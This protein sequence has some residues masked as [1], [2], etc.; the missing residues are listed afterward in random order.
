MIV[1]EVTDYIKAGNA[2]L[3]QDSLEDLV[4][5]ENS[6]VRRHLAENPRTPA[7]FLARLAADEQPEVRLAV[8]SNPSTP[9][10]SLFLLSKDQSSDVRYGIAEDARAPQWILCSLCF[11]ENPY[12]ASRAETTLARLHCAINLKMCMAA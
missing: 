4:I 7:S 6:N 5:H 12:V 3:S 2:N 10:P 11:D 1:Q 9:F 8:V